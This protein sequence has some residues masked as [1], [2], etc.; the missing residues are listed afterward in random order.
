MEGQEST[1]EPIDGALPEGADAASEMTTDALPEGL[2]SAIDGVREMLVAG[3][4]VVAILIALSVAALGIV[5]VK[6]WQFR[7]MRLGD[8]APARRALALHQAGKTDEALLL[9]KG[10]RNPVAQVLGRAI[11]GQRRG[12]AEPKIREEVVR[13]GADLLD[14]LRALFRPLEVIASLAP[15]LGLF[16]TVLG[17]IEAFQNLAAAG[18][19]VDPSILSG[20]IWEAL[21]TTAVGLA[22]AIPTVA[23]LNW[24]ERRVDRVARDLDSLVTQVFTEDLSEESDEH[25][26]EEKTSDEPARLRPAAVS[27]GA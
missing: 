26:T 13:Y 25:F 24:L 2:S 22:V 21:L 18:N 10:A 8:R 11:R 4:P 16:G 20:G 9:L 14:D 1:N 19:R 3:G 5:F 6:L 23:L 27:S 12:V 7:H 15:L 17:M